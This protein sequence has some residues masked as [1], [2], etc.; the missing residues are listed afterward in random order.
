MVLRRKLKLHLP[1]LLQS[2][3]LRPHL[4]NLLQLSKPRLNPPLSKTTPNLTR[5]PFKRPE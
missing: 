5:W 4:P 1:N 2:W 3:N